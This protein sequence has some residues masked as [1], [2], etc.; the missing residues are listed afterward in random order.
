MKFNFTI[1]NKKSFTLIEILVVVSIM[2]TLSSIVL[3]SLNV[4]RSKAKDTAIK[5]NLNNMGPQMEL[6]YSDNGNYFG[7]NSSN[8]NTTCIGP[9]AKMAE[10]IVRNGA[11]VRCFSF[12]N[13][14]AGDLYQRWAASS[15]IYDSTLPI[16]AWSSSPGGIVTW[17]AKGVNSSGVPVENDVAM[18]WDNAVTACATAGGRLPTIEELKTLINATYVA[19]GNTSHTPPGFKTFYYWSSTQ[20]P[21]SNNNSTYA[22]TVSLTMS[23]GGNVGTT[24][25]NFPD[26]IYVHCVR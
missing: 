22:Y 24:S 20:S 15:I 17:D 3:A 2:A 21:P 6:S 13:P 7:I 1:E 18:T 5:S 16:K 12:Y 9:I 19:S 11:T 4:T 26:Y 14:L 8:E 25:K 23:S 10:A